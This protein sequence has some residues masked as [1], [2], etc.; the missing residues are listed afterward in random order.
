MDHSHRGTIFVEDAEVLEHRAFDGDQHVLRVRAPKCAARAR[1]GSF[2]H[3][4][5]D[6]ALPMRRPMSIMRVSPEDGWVEMLYKA[7]GEGTRLL[8]KRKVGDVLS[9]LG[10]I[11]VPFNL[12]PARP[13]PLLIGGGV[14]IPPMVFIADA[15]RKD[16][17]TGWKP[18]VIMGSEVPFPFKVQPSKI[19]VPGLP[20][21]VIG[22]MP[23]M[24]DWNIPSR[25]ASLQGYAGCFDGYVTELAAH[26]LD[27]LDEEQKSEVA[28]YSCGPTPMLKAVAGLAADYG[29]PCEVSLEEH[30]ACAVGGC[31]GCVVKVMTDDGPAMKRVC[32]D[33][34]VFAAE[35]VFAR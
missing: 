35:K 2:V 33:G 19:M 22:G 27:S 8:A 31:A 7:I 29:I 26:W 25:L 13:R 6:P 3:L 9:M 15:L 5:C 21:G 23:L 18:F 17:A 12:D 34:P 10:P 28:I 14:G 32:V 16:R 20:D 4:S 1:P 11:G 30:M 24:D